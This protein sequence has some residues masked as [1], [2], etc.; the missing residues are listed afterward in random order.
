MIKSLDISFIF[1]VMKIYPFYCIL[2]YKSCV[3]N[4][5]R[6]TCDRVMCCRVYRLKKILSFMGDLTFPK[7]GKEGMV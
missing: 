4:N 6:S 3:E 2:K 7:F 5:V 1:Q